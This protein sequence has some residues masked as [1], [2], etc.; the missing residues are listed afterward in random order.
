[1][2]TQMRE[3]LDR[4][5]PGVRADLDAL[6]RI[7]S[8][9]ADPQ[10][11]PEI[12][13]TAAMTAQLF[14]DV[15]GSEVEIVDDG[16]GRHPAVVASWPAPPGAPTVLLY[17]HHDVVPA[18]DPAA[19][20]SPPFEPAERD[21]RL[22]ARGSADDKAG[23]ALHLAALRTYSGRPPIG[24]TVFVEGEEEAG[25]RYLGELLRRYSDKLR[26]DVVVVAD[27]SNF[28]PGVPAVTTTLR[29]MADVVVEVSVLEQG[30]HSGVFGG[31]V[32]DA[33]TALCR[34]LA[35]LHDDEGNVAVEGLT[36]APAPHVDYSQERLR[37]EATVLNGVRLL[38]TGTVAER[39]WAKPAASV[40][41]IDA[42]PVAHASK[43]LVPA[44]RAEVS[45]R[46][47]PGDDAQRAQQ[48]LTRHLHQHAPWGARVDVQPGDVAQP[49]SIDAR[50]P[51]FD[52]A[53]TALCE[54]YGT[55]PVDMG[56]G[57]DIPFI[58]EI[59]SW[60][61]DAPLIVVSPGHD[62]KS[63]AHGPDES[64]NLTDFTRACFAEVLLI[65]KLSPTDVTGAVHL[66][67]RSQ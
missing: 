6:I 34:L 18:G 45:L 32:P 66:H 24:V 2:N 28:Q 19:W 14:R 58:A 47:A 52:A 35:T 3:T 40:L 37:A 59:S 29:G 51:V 39:I 7:P 63:H 33:L 53:R 17:A 9:S 5:L 42:P 10:A 22:Y 13:R 8:V 23:I 26:A 48:A 60:L 56:I 50:G 55:T 1:M 16:R 36:A 54:A 15:D 44:A 46:L 38:G 11:A 57:G 64:L 12:R 67:D 65:S 61:P 41:A 20:T 4:V 21:G 62:P 31:P 27:G 43:T 25:S 49:V 30:A